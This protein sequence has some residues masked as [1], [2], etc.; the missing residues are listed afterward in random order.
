MEHWLKDRVV[1]VTGASG[2][3]GGTVARA[4]R[5]H[6]AHVALVDRAQVP[7][8]GPGTLS[9]GGVDLATEAGA[10]AAIAQIEEA[11]G[12]LDVLVNAAG[13]FV[14]ETV[15]GG[16]LDS[17]DRMF[18]INLRT[19]LA[20]CRAALPALERAGGGAIVNV[21]AANAAGRAGAALGAYAASKAGV[22]KLTE[23]LAAEVHGQG[24]RVNAV[25]PTILDTP[26]NRGA[27]PGADVAD[28]V[29]PEA[30]SDVIL[31]LCS[32]AA[33]AVTGALLQVRGGL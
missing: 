20:S 7:E 33:R 18:T 2:Q 10:G 1:V 23:S 11:L 4:A 3:L 27:M 12:R 8:L 25:L 16:S 29:S 14:M 9:V 24:I 28:W 15:A 5:A 22:A 6:G 19:A 32:P 17:W 13:G 30:L 31:F 21:G 26:A